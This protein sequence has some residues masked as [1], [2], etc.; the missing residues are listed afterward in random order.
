M[1]G[2]SATESDCACGGCSGGARIHCAIVVVYAINGVINSAIKPLLKHPQKI[3]NTDGGNATA[4][5]ALAI[6][7][8]E[9]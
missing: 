2:V 9:Q 6:G 5:R 7:Q 4:D 8:T 3:L 1:I